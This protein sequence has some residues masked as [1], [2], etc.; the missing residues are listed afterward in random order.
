[1][2]VGVLAQMGAT[3]P[4]TGDFRYCTADVFT[5]AGKGNLQFKLTWMDANKASVWLEITRSPF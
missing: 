1:M 4:P 2:T 5:N 3:K